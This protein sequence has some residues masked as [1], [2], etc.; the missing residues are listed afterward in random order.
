VVLLWENTL[1][2]SRVYSIKIFCEIPLLAGKTCISVTAS[3]F[4]QMNKSNISGVSI[5]KVE[6]NCI[7][8]QALRL[9]TG[10][11]AHRGE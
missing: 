7:L 2:S 11:T 3:N 6:K 5:S 10:R 9:Y 8:V 4:S 1:P